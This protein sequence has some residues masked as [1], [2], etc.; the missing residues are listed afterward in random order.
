MVNTQVQTVQMVRSRRTQ[1]R[2]QANAEQSNSTLDKTN[3]KEQVQELN[4]LLKAI[5]LKMEHISTDKTSVVWTH[6]KALG[7]FYQ[8]WRNY[9]K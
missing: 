6:A 8:L 5:G 2:A 9:P 4:K 1:S 7:C 3:F